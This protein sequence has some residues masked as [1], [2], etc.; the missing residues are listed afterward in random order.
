MPPSPVEET[1]GTA[2]DA[3]ATYISTAEWF[4]LDDYCPTVLGELLS[5]RDQ[6]HASDTYARYLTEVIGLELGLDERP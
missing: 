5:Y 4:C 6:N 3:E 1:R 2:D